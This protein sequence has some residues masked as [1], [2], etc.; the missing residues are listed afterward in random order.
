M[1]SLNKRGPSAEEMAAYA[2]LAELMP[3]EGESWPALVD[4]MPAPAEGESWPAEGEDEGPPSLEDRI[5]DIIS[6]VESELDDVKSNL[7]EAIR[8]IE[9][10]IEC[11][12]ENLDPVVGMCWRE[13][14]EMLI[15]ECY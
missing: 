9:D 14:R 1:T 2:A 11:W 5:E 4:P 13:E 8:D 10:E 3:A 15:E 12:Y 6:D 7:S